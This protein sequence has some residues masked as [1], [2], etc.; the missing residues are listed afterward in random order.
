MSW[1]QLHDREGIDGSVKPRLR[2][3]GVPQVDTQWVS[4]SSAQDEHVSKAATSFSTLFKNNSQNSH[5]CVFVA[6]FLWLNFNR[7]KNGCH[8]E[9]RCSAAGNS[10]AAETSRDSKS[11]ES[12]VGSQQP[13]SS[14]SLELFFFFLASWLHLT[15][16]WTST[17]CR[18]FNL[19]V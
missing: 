12:S 8:T 5:R 3:I 4:E 6:V 17:E 13:H 2:S 10:Q 9:S 19:Q 11:L 18:V 15:V 1:N 16:E 14:E 7:L